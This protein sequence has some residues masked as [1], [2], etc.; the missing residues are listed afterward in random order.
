MTRIGVPASPLRKSGNDAKPIAFDSVVSDPRYAS[1][2]DAL[3][4]EW[5]KA[6]CVGRR[7]RR[8]TERNREYVVAD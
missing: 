1:K 6:F 5:T 7:H 3:A 2:I 8:D 4:S